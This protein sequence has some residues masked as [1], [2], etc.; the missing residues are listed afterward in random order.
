VDREVHAT[1]GREA[2]ATL[3]SLSSTRVM[4]ISGILLSVEGV[5]RSLAF[6]N[7]GSR[8]IKLAVTH[9]LGQL[10]AT[11]AGGSVRFNRMRPGKYMVDGSGQPGIGYF[12]I[13]AA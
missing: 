12:V 5:P 10:P 11:L 6:G 7:R 2:G 3:L 13:L 8:A 1:A 9:P 4:L